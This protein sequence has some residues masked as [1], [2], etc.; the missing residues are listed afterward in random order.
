MTRFFA[1]AIG[2]RAL[3]FFTL[4]LA[5]LIKP[6][7]AFRPLA[8]FTGQP[9]LLEKKRSTTNNIQQKQQYAATAVGQESD[10]ESQS[11]VGRMANMLGWKRKSGQEPSLSGSRQ[12]V[13]AAASNDESDDAR[14]NVTT[15]SDL[16]SY[17]NDEEQRFRN[18]KGEINYKDLLKALNVQGDTQRLGSPDHPEVVHS[19]AQLIHH[20]KKTHSAMVPD[21]E[22]R[23]DGCRLALSIEGGGMR[24]CVS[25]GMI[26][27]LGHLNLTD[28]FDVVYGSSAG[29][30][31]G[32]YLITNQ[33]QWFGPEVYYDQLTTAG[34]S[35][36]D[37]RRIMRALGLGLLNPRLI[38]DV[39]VR[40]NNGKPILNLNFLLKRTV[41]KT[42]PLDWET[43]VEKQKVQPLRVVA[44][45]LKSEKAVVMDMKSGH[46]ENLA[47][48][49]DC[50]HASCLL[51]G[52]AGPLMNLD[53]SAIAKNGQTAAV[54]A[55]G[56]K[57][58]K[59]VVGNNLQGDEYEPMADALIC[60]PLPY[61]S[62]IAEGCTHALVIRSRPD[63]VD[64]TGKS[65]FFENLIFRRFF[66]RKNKLPRMFEFFRKQ[67]HK[68][69]YA[70]DMIVLNEAAKV[71][72]DP[73]EVKRDKDGNP[74]DPHLM[75][76]AAPPGSPEVTR[77]ETGREAIF[78]GFRRG[79]ARAYDCLVEDPAE[80]GRGAEV[81][82]EFFPDEILDYN[83]TDID[84]TEQSAFDVYLRESGVT[85]KAWEKSASKK[86]TVSSSAYDDASI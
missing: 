14:Y 54:G 3:V 6:S 29:T 2:N 79:F 61:R 36:I 58:K 7:A 11:T 18:E 82:R 44:S 30:I 28:V 80:R 15:L 78:E 12:T 33:L 50:M 59:L 52:I 56:K 66:L 43:F 71:K 35:F 76:I 45:G 31:V 75:T 72:R 8:G 38:K 47:E 32:A 53:T 55:D 70:Q 69:L 10:E 67:L 57:K 17:Y 37:T 26:C 42:K 20:R 74:T 49:T 22:T 4:F 64:V 40:R 68:K 21:G 83:P 63:G 34:R 48:L 16:D 81:A 39:L 86:K 27:A 73:F 84:D 1:K 24:G 51:P 5:H 19:V 25:A 46:F 9:T 41:Q 60:E 85:P 23:E 62:A 77:L 13:F 65:S